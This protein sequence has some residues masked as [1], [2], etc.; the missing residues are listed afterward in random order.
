MTTTA[1]IP[2][3]GGT[4]PVPTLAQEMRGTMLLFGMFALAFALLGV[5]LGAMFLLQA[6]LSSIS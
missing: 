5:G 2:V 6:A 3:A 1:D 4:Q